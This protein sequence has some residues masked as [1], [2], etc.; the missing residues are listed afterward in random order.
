MR[1]LQIEREM[2]IIEDIVKGIRRIRGEFKIKPQT[3]LRALCKTGEGCPLNLK[4]HGEIIKN[5][6]NLDSFE[7]GADIERPSHSVSFW[8][9]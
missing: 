4:E 9:R 1:N 6:A 5:M 7:M 2:Q 8:V 3:K